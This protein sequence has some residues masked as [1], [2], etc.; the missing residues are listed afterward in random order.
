[1]EPDAMALARSRQVQKPGRAI[2]VRAA[3]AAFKAALKKGNT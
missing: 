1:V 3:A 2:E